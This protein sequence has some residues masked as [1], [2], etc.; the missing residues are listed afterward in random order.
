MSTSLNQ[1][2]LN[3][4]QMKEDYIKVTQLRCTHA[5][6]GR[7]F[8]AIWFKKTKHFQRYEC[9]V[10]Q[11]HKRANEWGFL[12]LSWLC[13]SRDIHWL[14]VLFFSIATQPLM[15]SHPYQIK[16][17]MSAR[18]KRMSAIM[19][20][21]FYTRSSKKRNAGGFWLIYDESYVLLRYS[22]LDL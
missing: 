18:L 16:C 22:T 20:F 13:G 4:I 6:L 19:W 9:V 14:S 15:T 3:N 21:L 12:C 5:F 10:G 2:Y 11:W 7:G 1:A 17:F 8:G